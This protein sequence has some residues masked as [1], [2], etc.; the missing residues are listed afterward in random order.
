MLRFLSRPQVRDFLFGLALL[1][2]TSALVLFPQETMEAARD[3]LSLCFHVIVPSLFPFFV[4]STLVVNLGLAGHLGKVMAPIMVPL[5]RVPG[6]CAPALA[7]GFVGGYP[8]GAKTALELYDKGLC[9]RTEAERLLAFCNNSGPAF[10][11]GVVGSGIFSSSTIG[12]LLYLAHTLASLCVGLMFRFY[13]R[14]EP[15][16]GRSVSASHFQVTRFSSAFTTAVKSAFASTLNICAF[17]V[18][19]TVL[20]TLLF[21]SGFLPGLAQ[22]LGHLGAPLGFSPGWAEQLLT[23][24]IELTS[25]VWSLT[26]EGSMTGRL[27]MAAFLLGWAGL[28]V[29]C[30]VLS[31]LSESDL[32]VRPYLLGKLLHG[33]LSALLMGGLARLLPPEATISAYLTEQIDQVSSLDF[34]SSL[35]LSIT[36]AWVMWL[37]FFVFALVAI[38]KT[39]RKKRNSVVE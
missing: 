2:A 17:V 33:G 6:A 30:Q 22:I 24:L 12:L 31:F 14:H 10:I 21:Q 27:S 4:L 39:S 15:T 19:F 5:F 28:S 20:I 16:G 34:S 32:S 29:H 1:A 35:A 13:G 37:L 18:F 9:S 8:V 26:A 36:A 25:G 3:G 38:G 11:L 7:L 23:G